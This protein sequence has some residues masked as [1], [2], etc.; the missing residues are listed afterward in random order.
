MLTSLSGYLATH[1]PAHSDLPQI[2]PGF[3]FACA[4]G[5]RDRGGKV[6]V[7]KPMLPLYTKPHRTFDEQVKLLRERGMGGDD[8][9]IKARLEATNYYRLSGYFYFFR[10]HQG[11]R[12]HLG[13]QYRAGLQFDQVWE[14]YTFDAR[15]RALLFEAIE[16]IEVAIRTQV[17]YHHAKKFGSF[18]YADDAKSLPN[19]G[20]RTLRDGTVIDKRVELLRELA[21]AIERSHEQFVSHFYENYGNQWPP[22]WLASELLTLG[23]I[24]IIYE[25]S[26][27][28]VKKEVA[29]YFDVPFVVLESW[30]LTLNTAR[31]VCAHHGRFWNR[32][33]GNPPKIPPEKSYAYWHKPVEIFRPAAHGAPRPPTTFAILSV[34]NHLL[35]KVAPGCGWAKRVKALLD[36]FPNVSRM[37]MGFPSNW[38]SS[39]VWHDVD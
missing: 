14:L 11:M 18:A 9:V 13:E 31:N 15:L 29:A 2:A 4:Q 5:S 20:T 26:P 12:R 6:A 24:L 38:T 1:E 32:A 16:K 33:L 21:R 3:P 30:L 19:V 34:C 36:E 7:V 27:T 10:V 23:A 39:P 37:S 35:T 28:D 22:I 25:S 17:S 8:A